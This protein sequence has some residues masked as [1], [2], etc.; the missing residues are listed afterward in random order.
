MNFKVL[1][2]CIII[3]N[4]LTR[5]YNTMQTYPNDITQILEHLRSEMPKYMSEDMLET[6]YAEFNLN[7]PKVKKASN[8][9]KINAGKQT[10]CADKGFE[11]P[12][13]ES[14]DSINSI[15]VIST[16][17]G[18]NTLL[19]NA[20]INSYLHSETDDWII[21][22]NNSYIYAVSNKN[23]TINGLEYKLKKLFIENPNFNTK[24][25]YHWSTIMPDFYSHYFQI[26][27]GKTRLILHWNDC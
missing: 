10:W 8:I 22:G 25:I 12:E 6:V 4:N 24:L 21:H 18:S 16:C 20:D 26:I 2:A 13:S 7:Y 11:Y 3:F 14:N 27:K 5:I 17:M 23:Y 1:G 9:D 19:D 15:K